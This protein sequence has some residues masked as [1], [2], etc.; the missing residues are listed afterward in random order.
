MNTASRLAAALLPLCLVAGCTAGSSA[1]T[2]TG[3]VEDS[4]TSVGVPILAAAV[5]DP[6]AGFADAA[7][8]PAP[9]SDAASVLG[10]G[11]TVRISSV[12]VR[13]GDTVKA[14]QVVA[15]VDVGTLRVQLD[16]A[17]ADQLAVKAQVDV[18]GAAIDNTYDKAK[19]VADAKKKIDDAISTV[20]TTQA[21]LDKA[22]KQL[23]ALRPQLVAKLTAAEQLLANYPPTP[24]PGTPTQDELKAA[25]AQLRAAIKK[26]DAGIEQ[27]KTAQ[28]KLKA[29]LQKAR[30]GR[31][32]LDDA[33]TKITDARGTLR[34]A[35]ELARIAAEASGIPVEIARTQIALS[36][37]TAPVGGV[38]TSV[39]Q[40]GDQLAAGASVVEI[41]EDGPSTVAA[42][43]SPAE[44]A[45]MCPGE[46]AKITGD[47]MPAGTWV[48]ASLS[49]L[50]DTYTYPP[51]DKTT[52]EIHLTRALEVQFTA[53]SAQLPPG[54]P[55]DVTITGCRP[56]ANQ[57]KTN[58]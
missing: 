45:Q 41:R 50:G 32:K 20:I 39:A 21:K 53:T 31:R 8:T 52:N 42:W 19:D 58:G 26:V 27:I 44:A 43:L 57:N 29:G 23:K 36:E 12:K 3:T 10:L 33:G 55:V 1:I 47:W 56:A 49:R 54:V 9:T 18:L 11:T 30:E 17:K 2:V 15:T 48:D 35:Q 5:A 16:V 28:P 25:I 24:P 4:V 34:D 6:E 38:V 14:G 13:E 46:A 51:S 22:L 37:L 40:V 7:Q